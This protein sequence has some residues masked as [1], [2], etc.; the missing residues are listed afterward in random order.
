[1]IQIPLKADAFQSFVLEHEDKLD[2]PVGLRL[3]P[4][5]SR[6]QSASPRSAFRPSTTPVL[7]A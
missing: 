5:T 7:P 4:R 6:G 1:M 2:S 3:A